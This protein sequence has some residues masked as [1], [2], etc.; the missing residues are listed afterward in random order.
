MNPQGGSYDVFHYS[1]NADS[2]L[3]SISDNNSAYQ[4]HYNTD[5]ELTSQADAGTTGLPS[6]T[7][8]YGYDP[9]GNRTSMSDSLGG[10]VTYSYDSRNVLVNETLSGSGI[11][12][13]VAVKFAY[14]NAGN[15][16]GLTRY[17]NLAETTVVATTSYTY[18]SANQMTGI[19]DKNSGGTTLVEG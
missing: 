18:D 16:T 17:S 1:Y 12:T 6:V 2:Q 4:Y 15:L 7:L 14:D 19:V 11:T 13:P 3:T 10:V 5:G 8:N 9:A